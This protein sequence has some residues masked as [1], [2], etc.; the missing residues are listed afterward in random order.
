M[1]LIIYVKKILINVKK[2][3]YTINYIKRNKIKI[4]IL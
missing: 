3:N 2:F 4:N 1:S